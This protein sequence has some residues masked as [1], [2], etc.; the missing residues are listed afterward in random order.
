VALS[1]AT[2]WAESYVA[3][4]TSIVSTHAPLVGRNL[5]ALDRPTGGAFANGTR[6]CRGPRF[7]RLAGKIPNMLG[8]VL[9]YFDEIDR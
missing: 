6:R 8:L 2:G 3:Q 1:A 5:F 9:E 7:P 4:L